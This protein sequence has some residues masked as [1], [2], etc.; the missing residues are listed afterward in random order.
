M[1]VI[2]F[3][4]LHG[5]WT[6]AQDIIAAAA[7]ADVVIGAGDFCNMR[8]GLPE[9]MAALEPIAAKA[10]LVA[11]NAESAEELRAATTARVLHGEAATVAEIRLFGL[12]YAVPVTPFGSW[13]CD[14]SEETAEAMLAA[15]T[16]V[17]ILIT[18]APPKGL[19]DRTSS[20]AH[21]GSLAIRAA[22]ERVQPRFALCGHIHDSWGTVGMI[23]ATTVMNL[24]PK[25]VVIPL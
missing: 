8:R 4:D 1:R 10:V 7:D 16:S 13:S 14:L 5:S 24:G 12:G 19:G 6:G 25:P 18:H 22:I 17:D 15:L 2:A 3:S 20:G 23:G 21:V 9:A 11:G